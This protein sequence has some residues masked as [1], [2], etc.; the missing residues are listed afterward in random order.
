MKINLPNRVLLGVNATKQARGHAF[1]NPDSVPW[2]PGHIA[3]D[4][5]AGRG[6]GVAEFEGQTSTVFKAYFASTEEY[7][8]RLRS[9]GVPTTSNPEP[10]ADGDLRL[11]GEAITTAARIQSLARPGE[12]LLDGATVRAAR[13]RL[14]TEPSGHVVLRGQA[15]AVEL[16][17]LLERVERGPGVAHDLAPHITTPPPRLSLRTSTPSRRN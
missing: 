13:G 7:E 1:A 8:R 2:V 14:T 3:S 9:L 5:R 12:I 11:T 16:H 4:A 15:T 10:T 17:A 6:S